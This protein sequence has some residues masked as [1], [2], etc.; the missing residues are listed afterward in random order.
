MNENDKIDQAA[1]DQEDFQ[2]MAE[3]VKDRQIFAEM[4]KQESEE[5]KIESLEACV[6][7]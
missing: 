7:G 1:Q 6:Q 4:R 2:S 3:S 5:D